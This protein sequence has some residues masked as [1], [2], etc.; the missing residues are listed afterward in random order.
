MDGRP[1]LETNPSREK[2]CQCGQ[3]KYSIGCIETR[4][5]WKLPR[6]SLFVEKD[7]FS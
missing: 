3:Y 7:T 2:L 5:V 1:Y 6:T 4:L